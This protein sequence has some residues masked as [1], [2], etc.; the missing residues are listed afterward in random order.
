[1]REG[2]RLLAGDDLV[3]VHD[4]EAIVE[5]V[6]RPAREPAIDHVGRAASFADG[7]GDVGRAVDRVAGGEDERRSGLERGRVG[8]Q[9]AALVGVE[10]AREHGIRAHADG[11]DD[12]VAG[13]DGLAARDRLGASPPGGIRSA[14]A[15]LRATQAADRAVDVAEDLER[16]DLE[17]EL[18]ALALGVVT[19]DV[20]GGHVVASAAIGDRHRSRAEPAGCPGRVHRDVAATDND[21]PLVRQVHRRAELDLAQ[22]VGS[23]EDAE[24]VLAGHAEVRGAMGP[25]RDEDGVEATVLER[26]QVAD[27]RVGQDLDADIADVLDITLDDRLGQSI[28]GDREAQ[29]PTG[30]RR[31]FQDRDG[32]AEA[33]QLPRGSESGRPRA[34]DGNALAVGRRDLDAEFI[35]ARVVGV[36]DEPL[37]SADREGSFQRSAGAVRLARR[38]AGAAEGPDER[39]RVEDEAVRLLVLAASDQGHIAVGLD[40]GRAGEGARR[41]PGPIDDGLLRDGLGERDVGGPPGDEVGIELI[42]DRDGAGDL[43]QGAAGARWTR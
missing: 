24:A 32:V 11:A 20:V 19:L 1:M 15:H 28:R 10:L 13:E 6:E 9:E 27:R 14:E 4:R 2:E 30:D 42:G 33:G 29:E 21:D 7:S 43:A 3:L 34:D 40:P 18:H 36:G 25:G 35:A 26:G 5:A 38:V 12:D 31:G 16:G 37:E 22:E 8:G 41:A 17:A 23:P 39:R